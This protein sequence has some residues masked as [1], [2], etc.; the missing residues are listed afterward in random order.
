MPQPN[1]VPLKLRTSL[2]TQSR[3]MSAGTST[4]EV[5]PLTFSV[6]GMVTPDNSSVNLSKVRENSSTELGGL[7]D[8]EY[9]L[10]CKSA[11]RFLR[12]GPYNADDW[13]EATETRQPQPR[14]AK[15]GLTRWSGCGIL[16]V[17][18]CFSCG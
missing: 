7:L 12:P 17:G 11:G 5:F 15:A 9:R 3:G 2:R 18:G 13:E 16:A 4:I 14:T 8:R 1:L 6:K 10:D